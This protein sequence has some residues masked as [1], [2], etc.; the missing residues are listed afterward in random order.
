MWPGS[1]VS[2]FKDQQQ[3]KRL[4]VQLQKLLIHPLLDLSHWFSMGPDILRELIREVERDST[5]LKTGGME[6]DLPDAFLKRE[7][8]PGGQRE[9]VCSS[10]SSLLACDHDVSS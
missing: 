10:D 4:Q 1:L 8:L 2:Y 6:N 9:R 3:G 7:A 5:S